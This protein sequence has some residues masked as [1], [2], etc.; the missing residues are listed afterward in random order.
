M[1]KLIAFVCLNLLGAWVAHGQKANRYVVTVPIETHRYACGADGK[2]KMTAQIPIPVEAPDRIWAEVDALHVTVATESE[3]KECEARK[4][5][6][7]VEWKQV[8]P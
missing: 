3:W 8:R 5:C 4:I 7:H 1:R 6:P 2:L